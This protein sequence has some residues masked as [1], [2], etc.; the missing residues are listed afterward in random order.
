MLLQSFLPSTLYA[1]LSLVG[2]YDV[3]LAGDTRRASLQ[4]IRSLKYPTGCFSMTYEQRKAA[5]NEM[6]ATNQHSL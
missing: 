5:P 2:D 1:L 6:A 3:A 4:Y